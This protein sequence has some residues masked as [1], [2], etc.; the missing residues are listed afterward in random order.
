MFHVKHDSNTKRFDVLV[1]GGGHAGCEAAAAAARV[2]AR[3]ALVTKSFSDLGVMSCNPAIGGLG[4][5]Q[6]VREID[7]LDGLMGR[8]A[9][10]AGIQFRVLNRSRGPAARGPRAQID[11]RLYGRA[12]QDELVGY[13]NLQI[14]VGMAEALRT[15]NGRA[16]GVVLRDGLVVD[17]GAVVL[18]AGTFL[19]GV[20]HIGRRRLSAG[21]A[22]EPPADA[23]GRNL[24]ALGLPV[25]RLKTGTPARLSANTINWQELER[26]PGDREPEPFSFLSGKISGPQ[27]DCYITRTTSQTHDIVREALVDSPL[28]TGAIVGRGP[29]YCPSIEDKVS[30]FGDR[31]G[32]QVFLEPEGFDT[33][34]IYPNGIST[35]LSESAQERFI[36]S[37]PGLET[38]QIL[39]PGYAIEYD[40][41][42]PTA[43]LPTLECKTLSGLFLAGQINGTTGYEEAAGQGLIAGVNAARKAAGSDTIVAKRSDGFIGVMIDDLISRGVTEPY[44]MFTSRS[45]FRLSL[46]A[47]N[48]DLRLTPLGMS[49]GCVGAERA[50]QFCDRRDEILSLSRQLSGLSL[51]PQQVHAAGIEV[52][53]DGVRRSAREL[54]ARADVRYEDLIGLWPGL[55]TAPPRARLQ[56]ETDAKY[57]VYLERQESAVADYQARLEARLPADM[58]Y[59]KLPGLSNELRTRLTQFRP[60]S[61]EHAFRVEGMTPAAMALLAAFA[62]RPQN[63]VGA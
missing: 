46:R 59:G 20:I 60:L 54:L 38:A 63:K 37:I 49:L 9:D 34:V 61:L 52:N 41:F 2:G 40:Y 48:A 4:K 62:R 5:G 27:I 58:D 24:E 19:R 43:L 17:A 12:M 8:I 50:R 53:A 13:P 29:R 31:D 22:G 25:G 47:D 42:D 15:G 35:S 21:R 36:R 11:R 44:R 51:T 32:H 18:T 33:D 56:V 7:A 26:Q 45:E 39:R 6:I 28:H 23:L 1:V 14:I 30:R 3:T 16:S 55:A 10:R 57:A